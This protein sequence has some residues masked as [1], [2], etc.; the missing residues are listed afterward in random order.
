MADTALHGAVRPQSSFSRL[1]GLLH[2][3]ALRRDAKR[4]LKKLNALDD[5]ML[6]DV[7]M[8]RPTMHDALAATLR[9]QLRPLPFERH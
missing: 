8:H 2:E 4:S 7:G 5:R 6:R 3:F 9:V 1:T